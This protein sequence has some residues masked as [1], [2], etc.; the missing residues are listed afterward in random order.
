[1]TNAD[2]AP[3]R[4]TREDLAAAEGGTV[5]DVIAANLRVLFCG[6]NPGLYSAAVGH[7]FARPGNRFWKAL[8]GAGFTE[9]LL[10]PYE[11]VTLPAAGLGI[12][13]LVDRA[14]AAASELSAAE[15]RNGARRLEGKVGEYGPAAVAFLGVQAYRTAFGRRRATVGAQPETIR[16]ARLW[17]LPNPSG[18]QARYQLSD[19]VEAFGDLRSRV[20]P[21]EVRWLVDGM[22]VIG[23]RPDGWWRDRDAAVRRLVERLARYQDASGEP[24]T[25]VFD[26]RPCGDL[27]EVIRV[28]FASRGGRNAADDEI[29]RLVGSDGDPASIRVVTSDV[30]L[31]GRVRAAGADVVSAGSFLRVLDRHDDG[32]APGRN[33]RRGGV[34]RP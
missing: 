7:H 31:A 24:V 20:S 1:M 19:L 3:W 6:I 16:G 21:P 17:V 30:D 9:R 28:R 26:G 32:S 5:P 18:A 11:D 10:S 23:S 2:T 22:N 25:A 8:H 33:R 13:N 34:S 14:T 29:V 15:L 12:T 27:S 4:P